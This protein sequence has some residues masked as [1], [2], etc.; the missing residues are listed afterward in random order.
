MSIELAGPDWGD[1]VRR[2]RRANRRRRTIATAGLIGI[3]VAGVASAYA[4]GH[5]VIDFGKARHGA[6]REVNDF[7]S[8]EVAAPRGMAPGVLPH[9]T[10]RITAVRVDGKVHVLYVAPTKRGGFCF[11]WS[12]LEGGCRADRHDKWSSHLDTGGLMGRYGLI[13]LVGSFFQANGDRLAMAFKDGGTADVPFVWVTAPIDAGFYLY[14][15]PDAHRQNATRPVSLSLYDKDGKLITREPIV[16][17]APVPSRAQ[18]LSG[19]PPIS[20]PTGGI[21]SQRRQLFDLRD[22]ATGAR[23]FLFEM[24]RRGGGTCFVSNGASGCGRG[25]ARYGL[26]TLGFSGTRLCC[27]VAPGIVRVEARFQDGDRIELYPKDGYLIF[28]IPM[29]HFPLGHRLVA[30]VGYDAA[31]HVVARGRI[32]SPADQAGIY[33]CK[34]PKSLGYGV[35]RCA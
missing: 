10:R 23:V 13:V 32:P 4:L 17:G 35:K 11:E 31:G 25:S 8:M 18:H 19:Y 26:L 28:P 27:S 24:P 33:P 9:Q 5:P 16:R 29:R 1:V 22:E 3:V 7:G 6:R 2:S 15:V 20:V 30:T 12:H 14:R 21:W 34:T